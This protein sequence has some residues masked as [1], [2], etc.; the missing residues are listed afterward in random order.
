MKRVL[1]VCLM[2]YNSAVWRVVLVWP[3]TV[4]ESALGRGV[5]VCV[6][7][8]VCVCVCMGVYNFTCLSCLSFSLF[9]L[10]S[11]NRFTS[12]SSFS[13]SS[14]QRASI[15][16]FSP[17]RRHWQVLE[18]VYP[19]TWLPLPRLCR[20]IAP[21]SILGHTIRLWKHGT[22]LWTCLNL[23]EKNLPGKLE[24]FSGRFERQ[25]KPQPHPMPLCCNKNRSDLQ[26]VHG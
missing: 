20:L 4:G 8:Y 19:R 9:H 24:Q 1:S 3:L 18:I 7:V 12:A 26:S 23:Q 6:C 2:Y 15:V 16:P 17:E 25:I 10:L 13:S 11:F 5:C 22:S 14:H 21:S